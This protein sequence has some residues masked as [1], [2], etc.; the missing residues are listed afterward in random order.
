MHHARSDKALEN[1][2]ANLAKFQAMPGNGPGSYPLRSFKGLTQFKQLA[3]YIAVSL[4]PRF[5]QDQLEEETVRELYDDYGLEMFNPNKVKTIKEVNNYG[6]VK[7][8]KLCQK[9]GLGI[10][11][12]HLPNITAT[13]DML[14]E[15][16]LKHEFRPEVSIS[17]LLLNT[18]VSTISNNNLKFQT[19]TLTKVLPAKTI[20]GKNAKKCCGGLNEDEC[21]NIA[22]CIW[23]SDKYKNK[24]MTCCM[25][26]GGNWDGDLPIN[27][28]KS[29]WEDAIMSNCTKGRKNEER[30][31]ANLDQ[32]AACI[33]LAKSKKTKS[34]PKKKAA[35][36]KKSKPAPKKAIRKK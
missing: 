35:K 3:L 4:I 32:V 5:Y 9:N 30:A 24:K 33:E 12:Y 20:R 11:R 2:L 26:C 8:Q 10:M 14:I 31:R 23:T 27:V 13:R 36:K 18:Y 25:D 6:L 7:L 16:L 28:M 21:E 34:A 15:R 29:D 17:I 1:H 19:F 22:C